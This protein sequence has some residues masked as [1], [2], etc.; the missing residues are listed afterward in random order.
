M[1]FFHKVFEALPKDL[2]FLSHGLR[3][4]L[5]KRISVN[6]S[7]GG[8]FYTISYDPSQSDRS[9][10]KGV[11]FE[12]EDIF[13]KQGDRAYRLNITIYDGLWTGYE[14]ERNILEF[15]EFQIDVSILKKNGSK[16]A[17]EARIM[18]LVQGLTSEHLNLSEL[19]ELE[20]KGTLYYQI[21]DL[22][23]GDY[24]AIDEKGQVF[25]LV[26]DPYKI[27]RISGSV[28]EFVADVNTGRFS[29]ERYKEGKNGYAKQRVLCNGRQNKISLTEYKSAAYRAV[30]AF[31]EYYL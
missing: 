21:K 22:E 3:A 7:M 18:T 28:R 30:T 11:Q 15:K 23:D 25:G 17:P 29:F 5:Y 4:G 12:L 10:A 31:F 9:M 16:F 19:S 20:V 1:A 26:H 14:I 2:Q 24:L 27:Q 8:N 6:H 13:I